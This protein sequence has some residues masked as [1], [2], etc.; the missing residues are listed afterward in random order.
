MEAQSHTSRLLHMIF[1]RVSCFF[2]VASTNIINVYILI[3]A[4][5]CGLS[6]GLY[7]IIPLS[8]DELRVIVICTSVTRLTETSLTC[9]QDI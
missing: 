5:D 4:T 6:G 2:S 3:K 1:S 7:T 9:C 8:F